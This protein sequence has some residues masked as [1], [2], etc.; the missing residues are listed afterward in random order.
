MPET[1]FA[2][3][4]R[5]SELCGLTPASVDLINGTI[6]IYGK[7]SGERLINIENE[8]VLSLLNKYY[9]SYS[10]QIKA[11]QRFFVNQK[12]FLSM[13][14]PRNNMTICPI[15]EDKNI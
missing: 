1:L 13:K 4:M 10:Q 7:G 9:N 2:T 14:H 5:I 12:E 8:D 6:L 15:T 3:G 11:C